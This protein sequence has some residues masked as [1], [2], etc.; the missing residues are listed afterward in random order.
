MN[1]IPDECELNPG[2]Q[3]CFGV[4]CPCSN[5]DPT[6]GCA[7]STGSGALLDG[8][9]T[10]SI[11]NDDLVLTGTNMIPTEPCTLFSADDALLGCVGRIFGDGIRCTGENLIRLQTVI[12]GASG[13]VTF[14]PGLI[15]QEDN[16][17]PG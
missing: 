17:F 9:G 14:G 15:A 11:S 5:P 12:V 1:G 16:P 6:A 8:S 7:N 2:L 10:T 13:D 3:Y 4:T